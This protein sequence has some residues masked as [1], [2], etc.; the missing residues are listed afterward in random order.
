MKEH[1]DRDLS[2]LPLFHSW[3][4]YSHK[5]AED[6][7][8]VIRLSLCFDRAS[9]IDYVLGELDMGFSFVDLLTSSTP[10][11]GALSTSRICLI[12]RG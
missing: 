2:K 1:F 7:I 8:D 3:K 11:S 6:G 10:R 5:G 12:A 9:S 4:V